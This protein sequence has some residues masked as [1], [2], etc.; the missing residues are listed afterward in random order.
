M[1]DTA[2]IFSV[3]GFAFDLSAPTIGKGFW[4]QCRVNEALFQ[5]VQAYSDNA[6]ASSAS[7]MRSV[8]SLIANRPRTMGPS[9]TRPCFVTQ[10]NHNTQTVHV[11]ILAT[12]G[13]RYAEEVDLL[14]QHF[15]ASIPPTPELLHPD[16]PPVDISPQWRKKPQYMLLA[17]VELRATDVVNTLMNDRYTLQNTLELI[18]KRT[19][20]EK[21]KTLAMQ[22]SARRRIHSSSRSTSASGLGSTSPTSVTSG[23]PMAT[24]EEVVIETQTTSGRGQN[25]PP[26]DAPHPSSSQ[27]RSRSDNVAQPSQATYKTNSRNARRSQSRALKSAFGGH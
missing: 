25:R 8:D 27:Q 15:V 17:E 10:V 12:F 18:W 21:Q 24:I 6:L 23:R 22:Y 1:S 14:T 2:S 11:F 26:K 3:N 4:V 19:C 7:S 16:S 9:K 5:N 13:K 20:E